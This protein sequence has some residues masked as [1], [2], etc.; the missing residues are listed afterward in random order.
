MLKQVSRARL[1][2]AWCAAMAVMAACGVV[3]GVPL[4]AGVVELLMAAIVVP[5]AVMLLVWRSAPVPTV[6]E[7]LYAVEAAP[8]AG[9]P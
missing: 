3:A 8:K 4:T 9:R 2:S 5:P 7:V 1:A 6:G